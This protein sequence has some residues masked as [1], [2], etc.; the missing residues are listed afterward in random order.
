MAC[1]RRSTRTA[2]V[3]SPRPEREVSHAWPYSGLGIHPERIV[4]AP[5]DYN[6]R[7]ERMHRSLKE[8]VLAPTPA[9]DLAHQQIAFERFR[10]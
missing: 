5:P 6:G 7:H 9:A 2:A 3:R 1:R 10:Q 4:P 8:A